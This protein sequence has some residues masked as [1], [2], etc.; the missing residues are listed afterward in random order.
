M[1]SAGLDGSEP[2]DDEATTT[3]MRPRTAKRPPR[4]PIGAVAVG[5]AVTVTTTEET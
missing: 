5:A 1:T 2:G 3:P 4:R